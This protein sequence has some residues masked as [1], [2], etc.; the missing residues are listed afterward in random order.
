MINMEGVNPYHWEKNQWTPDVIEATAKDLAATG[1][2]AVFEECF[3]VKADVFTSLATN[4][5]KS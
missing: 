3:E 2:D 1:V 5:K 4:I